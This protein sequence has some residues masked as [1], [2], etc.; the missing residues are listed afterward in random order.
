[1]FTGAEEASIC[2][3]GC[4][5]NSG[6]ARAFRLLGDNL[7]RGEGWLA[8]D[9][10]GDTLFKFLIIETSRGNDCL[11]HEATMKRLELTI[12]DLPRCWMPWTWRLTGRWRSL[13]RRQLR[14]HRLVCESEI[15]SPAS[16]LWS[17]AGF[18]LPAG[19]SYIRRWSRS[20]VQLRFDV[21]DDPC[22]RVVVCG[23]RRELDL[24][25]GDDT[26]SDDQECSRRGDAGKVFH[27]DLILMM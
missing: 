2:A 1:M 13:S 17:L 4:C 3:G 23:L 9:H 19:A 27:R 16:S 5:T 8:L 24:G 10:C 15:S 25:D 21:Q 14:Y 22:D 6:F 12:G 7:C 11:S 18:S 26:E 20:T